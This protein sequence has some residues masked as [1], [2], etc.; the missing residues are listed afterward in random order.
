MSNQESVGSWKCCGKFCLLE[1]Q[2]SQKANVLIEVLG[3]GGV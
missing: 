3:G 1:P 2:K